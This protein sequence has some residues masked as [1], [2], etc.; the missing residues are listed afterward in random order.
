MAR[1][2]ELLTVRVPS[3]LKLALTVLRK[4]TSEIVRDL[5][6]KYVVENVKDRKTLNAVKSE[7]EREI[8]TIDY[9]IAKLEMRISELKRRKDELLLILSKIDDVGKM[10][11]EFR[12]KLRDAVRRDFKDLTMLGKDKEM[13]RKFVM[14]R[15]EIIAD[16]FGCP[17][18]V[19]L[20]ILK[21]VYPNLYEV[22]KDGD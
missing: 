2:T 6:F 18:D 5:L 1:Y 13:L 7:C 12:E 19:V 9:E 8:K 20:E 10:V 21:E 15:V 22:V 4:D 14:R 3:M 17:E 11:D 16:G